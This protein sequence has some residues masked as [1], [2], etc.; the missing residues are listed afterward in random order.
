MYF[1]Y[2]ICLLYVF[3]AWGM[4]VL[5]RR[6]E[7]IVFLLEEIELCNTEKERCLVSI[8]FLQMKTEYETLHSGLICKKCAKKTHLTALPTWLIPQLQHLAVSQYDLQN[9]LLV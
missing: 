3:V 9:Q 4:M 2:Y 1:G 8:S 6:E 7:V 5:L